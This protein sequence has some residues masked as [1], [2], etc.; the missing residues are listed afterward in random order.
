MFSKF[1]IRIPPTRQDILHAC[2][3]AED[4]GV[5]YGFNNLVKKLP[6]THGFTSL[7]LRKRLA[8]A[9]TMSK[10][11]E[12]SLSFLVFPHYFQR[13]RLV[14]GSNLPFGLPERTDS[15]RST[16]TIRSLT[17]RFTQPAKPFDSGTSPSKCLVIFQISYLLQQN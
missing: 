8:F 17:I 15:S 9:L 16:F 11:R 1:Q 14:K 10:E 6:G 4:V 5:A 2:D 13:I 7:I 3:I 12:L